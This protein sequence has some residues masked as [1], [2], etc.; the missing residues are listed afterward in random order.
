M[1]IPKDPDDLRNWMVERWHQYGET[2]SVFTPAEQP[3]PDIWEPDL[4]E[5]DD[6]GKLHPDALKHWQYLFPTKDFL[7]HRYA[8]HGILQGPSLFFDCLVPRFQERM[9]Q[10]WAQDQSGQPAAF[11][12]KDDYTWYAKAIRIGIFKWQVGFS[13]RS[14]SCERVRRQRKWESRWDIFSGEF[15]T[16]RLGHK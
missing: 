9:H 7:R 13:C 6:K 3:A 2:F 14:L 4:P 15:G 10:R 5:Y 16:L 11:E 8:K 1:V 12:V